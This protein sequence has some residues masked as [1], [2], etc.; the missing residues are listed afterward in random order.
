MVQ[1]YF[2]LYLITTGSFAGVPLANAQ[3]TI[4]KE[5]P[6]LEQQNQIEFS[7][8]SS[9]KDLLISQDNSI[10]VPSSAEE[11]ISEIQVRFVDKNGNPTEG[12]TKPDIIIREFDLKP[13]DIYD[14]ELAKKGLEE[15]N[16]LNQIKNATIF[17]EPSAR[18]NNVVM[19][20]KVEES[21][22]F[23]FRFGQTLP[24]PTALNGP[25]RPVVVNPQ[26]NRANGIGGGVRIG[27]RNLGGTGKTITL[28]SE[29]GPNLLGFDFDYR[30]FV[31]HDL[32]YAFNFF[33]RQGK[34]PEFDNGDEVNLPNGDDPWIDR[35]G[36]GGEFFFP[37]TRDF[38]GAVGASYQL[39][40]ARDGLFS[41]SLQPVDELGNPLTISSDGQDTLLTINFRSV[42]DRRNNF[43]NPTRGYRFAF[44][45]DQS[46]PI[47]DASISHNRLSASMSGF[48][49]FKLFGFTEGDRTLVLNVQ[50]GTVIGD[51][52][53]YEA[54][55][56]G[57]SGSIR[58]FKGAEVGTGR[59][60]I[61]AT[62]E[63]R[64]P[65]FKFKAFKE[66]YTVG[67]TLFVDFGSDLGSGDTV[68]G[69]PAVI[70]DKPGNAFGY[71]FGLRLPTNIGTFRVELGLNDRGGG[72]V[73]FNIGERF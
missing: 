46:I 59:S 11:T 9:A 51:L 33:N 8:Y 13:G 68:I 72:V 42:L 16:K 69:E 70:R 4:T 22:T 47:G 54:F 57:G 55:N 61:T 12:K 58:G 23:F 64:F 67:G 60:F 19:V 30:Q 7:G 56:L 31:K 43:L 27:W 66:K 1:K 17:L 52:P 10:T 45:S 49:P 40:S 50:G 41:S 18:D 37:I 20:V 14:A 36:G 2:L 26:S 34:E 3:T 24:P 73:H 32:G 71:G 38:K 53:G 29:F 15:V 63:Y 28:G 25:A 44:G 39:V 35:T 48:I 65:M 6:S 62:A 5:N 21:N